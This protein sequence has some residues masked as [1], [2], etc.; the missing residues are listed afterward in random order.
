MQPQIL[1]LDMD[2]TLLRS[3]REVSPGH[4]ALIEACRQ[5]GIEVV[6]VT[7]RPL[8]TARWGWDELGFTNE[9]VCFNGAWVGIPG[10]APLVSRPLDETAVRDVLTTL[11]SFPGTI[12]VYPDP[13]VW[14]VNRHTDYTRHWPELYEVSI[15]EWPDIAA[16]WSGCSCKIMYVDEPAG[17]SA[18]FGE[19]CAA[20]GDRYH[21]VA[22][23]CD[24]VEIHDRTA[25]KAWGLA[26]IAAARG[27]PR[28]AVWAVGDGDNDR[29]MIS[30]AGTGF[31]MGNASP[32][33]RAVADALLP[34]VHDDGLLQLLERMGE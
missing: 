10:K 29:E 14:R 30:W 22:S 4:Q 15:D 32:G 27:V 34:S 20:L 21:V 33:L 6:I 28:E 13:M 1:A 12:N 19:L 17:V 5:R 11:A 23:E 26:Q 24:R 9:L 7:G 31:A 2:G 3:R 8:L 16:E 25:T 18:A